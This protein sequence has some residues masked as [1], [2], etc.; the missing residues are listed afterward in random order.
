MYGE[1]K[2][3]FPNIICDAGCRQVLTAVS[4]SVSVHVLFFWT[5]TMEIHGMTLLVSYGMWE[6]LAWLL[7]FSRGM[8]LYTEDSLDE[9]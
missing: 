1:V 7:G 3:V 8:A 5:M 6:T 2:R 9:M 4:A